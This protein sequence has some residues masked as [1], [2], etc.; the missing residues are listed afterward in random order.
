MQHY[1]HDL[2]PLIF[3]LLQNSFHIF[4][5]SIYLEGSENS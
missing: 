3:N 2:V 4:K 5:I 1:S